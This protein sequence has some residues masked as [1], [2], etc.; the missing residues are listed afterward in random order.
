MDLSPAATTLEKAGKDQK[1]SLILRLLPASSLVKL[2]QATSGNIQWLLQSGADPN[3]I[4][5]CQRAKGL[6]MSLFHHYLRGIYVG[7]P[8]RL[9]DRN[10]FALIDS[11]TLGW[12]D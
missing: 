10:L 2:S 3:Y 4:H 9:R 7:F 1:T 8:P 5:H 11:R 6:G 12:L